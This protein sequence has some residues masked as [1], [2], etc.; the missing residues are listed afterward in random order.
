MGE[1][2]DFFII[3]GIFG[4]GEKDELYPTQHF[5]QRISHGVLLLKVFDTESV[6][7]FYHIKSYLLVY[8]C[9]LEKRTKVAISFILKI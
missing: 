6:R 3:I 2:T 4:K 1:K 5:Y 8:C 7:D 9:I